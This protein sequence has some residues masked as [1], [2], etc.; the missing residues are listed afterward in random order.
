MR[1]QRPARDLFHHPSDT[2]MADLENRV[3]HL[4]FAGVVGNAFPPACQPAGQIEGPRIR[5]LGFLSANQRE[6]LLPILN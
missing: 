6:P 4:C 2:G 5:H 3:G 1:L